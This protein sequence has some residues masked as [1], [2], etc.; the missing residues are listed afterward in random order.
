MPFEGT[1]KQI[2]VYGV[3]LLVSHALFDHEHHPLNSS[4][5]G[6]ET[7]I[8]LEIQTETQL[9]VLEAG[10]QNRASLGSAE[11]IIGNYIFS[12]RNSLSV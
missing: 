9:E 11:L 12:K 2:F 3:F 5:I 8:I 7:Q 1:V 4:A 6:L 10:R